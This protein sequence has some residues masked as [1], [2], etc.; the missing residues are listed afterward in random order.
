MSHQI[1]SLLK[2]SDVIRK[3]LGNTTIMNDKK[4]SCVTKAVKMLLIPSK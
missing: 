2:K 1:Y 3:M 4:L